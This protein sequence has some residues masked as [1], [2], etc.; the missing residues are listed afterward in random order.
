[1]QIPQPANMDVI[2]EMI[3]ELESYQEAC[4]KTEWQEVMK[5]EIATL[6]QNQTWE[7]VPK[8]DDFRPVSCKWVYKVK[9]EG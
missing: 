3:I 5:T 2:K 7:L 8:P 6:I 1:M 4:D 9:K